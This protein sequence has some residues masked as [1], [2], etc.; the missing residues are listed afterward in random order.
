LFEKWLRHRRFSPQNRLLWPRNR[1]NSL[2]AGNSHGDW[3]EYRSLP[4]ANKRAKLEACHSV[5]V[6]VR[7]RIG[8]NDL[9]GSPRVREIA[10]LE[11]SRDQELSDGL[12]RF[13]C[14]GLTAPLSSASQRESVALLGCCA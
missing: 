13:P 4:L 1:K 14:A 9:Q 5:V 12:A 2:R 6:S 10:I 11:I 3:L 8:A 7:R